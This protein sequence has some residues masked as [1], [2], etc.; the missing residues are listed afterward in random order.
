MN[1][2]Y[3]LT[4]LTALLL[5]PLAALHAANFHVATTGNDANPGTQAAPL[6]SIQRAADLAQPGDTITV[7]EGTYRERINPPR[8]GTSDKKR[9]V[10]QVAR[11]EK[12]T[13]TGADPLKGWENVGGDTWKVLVPNSSFGDFNPFGHKIQGEWCEPTGRH[14][15]S[16][17][18]DGEWLEESLALEPVLKPVGKSP[19]WYAEVTGDNTTIW[20]QFPGVNPNEADVEIS[21]RQSVFYPSKTGINHIT[22]RGFELCRAATPWGGAMSEQV[23]LIGTH[24]SKGW[25]IEN[26]HI[27]HS[28]C[29]GV[30]LGRYE[31]PAK[32]VP[33]ATAPGFV[34][35]MEMALRDGWSK[36]TVGSHIVRNNRIHHCE[37]NAIH[38]SLGAAFSEISGNEIHDIS[39][40]GW[41]RGADT[42]GIKFL[43]GVDMVVRDNHI[44][45]CGHVAGIW[46]DWSCQ[47]ALVSGNL[48]HDNTG[49]GDIFLEMQHGPVLVANNI[50]LSPRSFSINSEGMALA[51][52]LVAGKIHVFSDPRATPFHPPHS[53]ASA[54]LYAACGGDH[55]V[56]NNLLQNNT[57]NKLKLPDITAGN[58]TNKALAPQLTQKSDGW[59]LTLAMDKSWR[60]AAN[61]KLVTTELLGKAKV[62]G[63][64]YENPDGSPLKV[65]ADYFGKRRNSDNPSPGPFENPGSGS[66]TLKVWGWNRE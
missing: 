2:N 16:V 19:L 4:L 45:R 32:E 39:R 40:T 3:P 5:A 38:G 62:S 56:I 26:N 46:L 60:Q 43:G 17:Y 50:L 57:F 6:R 53:V 66:L 41:V 33:P 61:S 48:L 54:G 55:R 52:N 10:Y 23:G 58:V 44:Y 9:I 65:D 37:K 20:A 30:A 11:S 27:H 25:I 21:K 1:P 35:S 36:E 29:K 22:V 12:V 8:G 28:M 47:G 42:G 59:Y 63:C 24:W 7:H 51:H 13:I 34:K 31:L 18:L 64:A 49:S 15:A 14:A